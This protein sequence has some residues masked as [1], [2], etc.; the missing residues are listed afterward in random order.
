MTISFT[1]DKG[2]KLRNE[3][4]KYVSLIQAATIEQT[5]LLERH[6]NAVFSDD[7]LTAKKCMLKISANEHLIDA[8]NLCIKS[9]KLEMIGG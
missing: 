1:I 2:S 6:A 9:L 5:V 3:L 4:K 8:Y 7:D